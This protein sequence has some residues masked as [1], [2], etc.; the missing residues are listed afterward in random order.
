MARR[1]GRSKGSAQIKGI[2]KIDRVKL[3][4]VLKKMILQNQEDLKTEKNGEAITTLLK[5]HQ[6]LKK[7]E[8]EIASEVNTVILR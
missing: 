5:T 4:T 7:L 8:K 2:L 6:Y 3:Y 1:S